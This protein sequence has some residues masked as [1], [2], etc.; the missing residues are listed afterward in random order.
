MTLKGYI[1]TCLIT[2]FVA[3]SAM[4]QVNNALIIGISDYPA[5][6]GFGK[7]HG[8]NDCEIIGKMLDNKGFKTATLVNSQATAANIRTELKKLA[9]NSV[10]GSCVYIHFSCHGQPFEDKQPFDEEDLWDESIVAYDAKIN[11]QSGVYEGENHILD[12]ELSH[13][14]GEIRRQIGAG[15]LLCVVIDA[16]HSG[17]SSRD[18]IDEEDIIRGTYLGFSE[19]GKS[20]SPRINKQGNFKIDQIPGSSDI[21]ILEAC[22]AYQYSKEVVK[23]GKHYGSLSYYVNEVLVNQNIT[24]SLDWVIRVKDLMGND[25]ALIDQNMVYESSFE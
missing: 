23:N 4:G 5:S 9:T 8:E 14:F 3:L 16:C 22:R 21:I 24:K 2:L 10:K 20:F 18:D 1:S 19:N 13:Y 12:D 6:S 7:I 11:Y 17:T 15:G 25:N